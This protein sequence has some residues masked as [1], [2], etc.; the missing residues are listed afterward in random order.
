MSRPDPVF[1]LT[2]LLLMATAILVGV[3]LLIEGRV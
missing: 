2:L 3:R 1:R